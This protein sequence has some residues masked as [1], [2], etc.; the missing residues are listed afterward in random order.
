MPDQVAFFIDLK[1]SPEHG[2]HVAVTSEQVPGLHLLGRSFQS[3]RSMIET[4]IKRLYKDNHGVV[5]NVIWLEDAA[6]FPVVEEV[7]Q[8]LAVYKKA[9]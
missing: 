9:A 7:P 6:K 3:M 1:V 2:G 5:V 8:R 4:A